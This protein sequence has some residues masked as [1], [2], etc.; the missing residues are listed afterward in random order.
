[1]GIYESSGHTR[2]P[3]GVIAVLVG[4]VAAASG[5]ALWGYQYAPDSAL[6]ASIAGHLGAGSLLGDRLVTVA[7]IGGAIACGLAVITSLT[8]TG[9]ASVVVALVLG[10]IGAS[11]PVLS[12]LDVITRP[13]AHRL[14]P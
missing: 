7:G 5:L 10:V 11:F 14:T 2:N 12:S 9:K 1:M 3:V 4:L 6:I 8:G 13:L